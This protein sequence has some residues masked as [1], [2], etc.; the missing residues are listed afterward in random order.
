[1]LCIVSTAALA[2]VAIVLIAGGGCE[3]IEDLTGEYFYILPE[4]PVLLAGT[5]S[6]ELQAVGGAP[7]YRWSAS[8]TNIGRIVGDGQ[9]VIYISDSESGVNVITVEDTR[10]W[11]ATTIVTHP[12][13]DLTIYVVAGSTTLST[14]GSQV[15]LG[16]TGGTAPYTWNVGN[17]SLGD[18]VGTNVGGTVVYMRNS[19][20]DNIVTVTDS[21]ASTF[22]TLILQP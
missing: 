14:N 18:I 6:I 22:N 7:P 19:A 3:N 16:S 9:E 8:D 10:Y 1:M 12:G 20:G 2:M 15:V 11:T 17:D 21:A 5:A 13:Q 4:N